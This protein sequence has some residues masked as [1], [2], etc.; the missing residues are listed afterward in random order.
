MRSRVT[1]AIAAL[2]A[3]GL[4]L[5][6]CAGPGATAGSDPNNPDQV[7]AIT[8][9][10]TGDGEDR[11]L[12]HGRRVQAGEP[13]PRL[14]RR[15]RAAAAAGR[16]H[17]QA[18]AARLSADN[19]PDTFQT[20]AGAG[21][22]D[23]VA[24]GELQDLTSFYAEN[25][26]TDVYRAALLELLSVDGKIYCGAR[27]DIHRVNVLW[28]N[29]VLLSNAGV[30][31]TVAPANIEAWLADLDKVRASGVEYPLALGNDWTQVQLFE[32]VLLADIGAVLY[33]NLWKS[34]KNWEGDALRKAIDHYGRL[35]DYVE[36][37]SGSMEWTDATN[38]RHRGRRRLRADGR[39]RAVGVP[40]G[41][42]RLRASSS[43][44]SRRRARSA[45]STSSPTRSRCRSVRCTTVP[46]APGC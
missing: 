42:V 33:Q 25:G 46:P 37:T 17:A 14:H 41:G 23:Y 26:L 9:W 34:T 16:R 15:L 2:A 12:R 11:A 32:N 8:W 38:E 3:I 1:G 24:H 18:I 45:S 28:S 5:V 4:V 27:A 20:A 30:D 44:P 40:A 22:S 6:G 29:N 19:P 39:L 7:E 31:P 35:L 21:L 36:P 13:R 43:P 10:T